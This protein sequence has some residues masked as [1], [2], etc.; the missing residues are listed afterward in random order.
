METI[1]VKIPDQGR[2]KLSDKQVE[3]IIS[4]QEQINE[5]LFVKQTELGDEINKWLEE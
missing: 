2:L 1:A 3:K 5:G 4:S